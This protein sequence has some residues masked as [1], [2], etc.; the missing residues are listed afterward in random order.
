MTDVWPRRNMGAAENWGRTV[1]NRNDAI[2]F[3]IS[4]VLQDLGG[5][6]RYSSATA[7]DL[8]RIADGVEA[9]I[10]SLPVTSTPGITVYNQVPTTSWTEIC[11]VTVEPSEDLPRLSLAAIAN[12]AFKIQGVSTRFEWP[13]PVGTITSEY[14]MRLNP[15]TGVWAMHWGV[16]FSYG[17]IGGTPIYAPGSGTVSGK[18]FNSSA[19]NWITVA[20]PGD[21]ETV[22]FHMQ[23]PSPLSIGDPVTIGTTILG[24]VG[25]TGSSTGDHLHWE[26][27]VSGV[28]WNPRDFMD[29]YGLGGPITDGSDRIR[30][31]I[32]GVAT[33][34]VY[35]YITNDAS[36]SF[37]THY[38]T[39]GRNLN[40]TSAVPVVL[41]GLSGG[42]AYQAGSIASLSVVA[43]RSP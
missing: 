32:D 14:G 16:D 35:S 3:K 13:F 19:G 38:A 28:H 40:T 17:G 23:A 6:N 22:Y 5:L 24:L 7:A 21:L 12:A 15:V 2:Q 33:T 1:E 42:G 25:T 41:E 37:V 34:P 10:R 20:H 30:F 26:T 8:M 29:V 43:V 4:S 36:G 31:V 39:T 27:L 9:G 11:R 18:G